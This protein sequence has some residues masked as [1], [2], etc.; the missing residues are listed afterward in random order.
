VAEVLG[1]YSGGRVA[2]IKEGVTEAC[3]VAQAIDRRRA[4]RARVGHVLALEIAGTALTPDLSLENPLGA[5]AGETVKVVGAIASVSWAGGLRDPIELDCWVSAAAWQKIA[6]VEHTEDEGAEDD[7]QYAE[8]AFSFVVYD[9]DPLAKSWYKSFHTNDVSL[10]GLFR[11]DG[12]DIVIGREPHPAVRSPQ[13]YRVKLTAKPK[14]P[15]QDLMIGLAARS[16][17]AKPWGE[18]AMVAALAAAKREK[19]RTSRR[20]EEKRREEEEKRRL[21]EEKAGAKREAEAAER[22]EREAKEAEERRLAEI[23]E[24]EARMAAESA[25]LAAEAEALEAKAREAEASAGAE[26]AARIAAERAAA[27]ERRRQHETARAAEAFA[28]REGGIR[29]RYGKL[30]AEALAAHRAAVEARERAL[31]AAEEKALG[32]EVRLAAQIAR[33]KKKGGEAQEVE[34]LAARVAASERARREERLLAARLIEE[35][36]RALAERVAFLE[37]EERAELDALAAEKSERL[38][39]FATAADAA[40]ELARE[41]REKAH[42]DRDRALALERGAAARR[43]AAE[44]A[45]AD[46]T[47]ARGAAGARSGASSA[48]VLAERAVAAAERAERLARDAR[49]HAARQARR[50]ERLEEDAAGTGEELRGLARAARGR[51]FRQDLSIVVKLTLAGEAKEVPG[52]A[53]SMLSLDLWTYGFRGEIELLLAVETG[54]DPLADAVAATGLG[55]IELAVKAKFQPASDPPDPLALKGIILERWIVEESIEAVVDQKVMRRRYRFAFADPMRALWRQHHPCELHAGKTL[56]EV[57]EAQKGGK[58]AVTGEWPGH[59]DLARPIIL[60]G[61]NGRPGGAS[62]YDFLIWYLDRNFGVLVYDAALDTYAILAAKPE[63]SETRKLDADDVDAL[64]IGFPEVPRH[65]SRVLN[66]CTEAATKVKEIA[67]DDAVAGIKR[68]SLVRTSIPKRFDDRAVIETARLVPRKPEVRISFAR[69]PTV[70]FAPGTSVDFSSTSWSKEVF[71]KGKTYR[72]RSYSIRGRADAS[73]EKAVEQ[74]AFADMLLEVDAVLEDVKDTVPHLPPYTPP[75]YPVFVE[76]K[77][78]SAGGGDE[79]RTWLAADDKDTS[80]SYYKV[81]IPLWNKKVPALFT[82]GLFPGHFFFPAWKHERVL[83]AF[84]LFTA[85][86]ARFLDWA[87]GARLAQDTQGNH[88]LPGKRA[89][90]ETSIRHDYVDEKPEL[91]IQ[92]E[93]AGDTQT[94]SVCEGVLTMLVKAE[95]S[96]AEAAP[97]FDVTIQVE[98]AKGELEM[99]AG[100]ATAAFSGEVAGAVAGPTAAFAGARDE[101]GAELD[102]ASS[103]IDAQAGEIRGQLE[104]KMAGLEGASAEM[105]A[106]VARALAELDGLT[107]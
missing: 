45:R 91:V 6:Q 34:A 48:L 7:E 15:Q 49:E 89:T 18:S 90:D 46:A 11:F 56:M 16:T 66:G 58:I 25:R 44:R 61:L 19:E 86:I 30:R 22:R 27:A 76:G 103:E 35:G 52:G 47:I 51:A 98:Q 81:D 26:E 62:F 99:Q 68:D 57:I 50:L 2:R 38:K 21:A 65:A 43:A 70:T 104:G 72:V 59:L 17:Q 5:A 75:E 3:D 54:S 92:R 107:A 78:V 4:L 36:A 94:I 8:C 87:P 73:R 12:R 101:V 69:F 53:V 93:K 84:D 33:L 23:A 13:L 85:E 63:A 71:A 10:K 77:V 31:A 88:L 83:V 1:E 97:K 9:Y 14:P 74:L 96:Q 55:E 32:E 102:S 42:T 37:R 82:G 29:E 20:V 64:E 24:R 106:G 60:L 79:D 105:D 28:G 40:R 95:E 100:G 67:F 80:I 41:A 39:A